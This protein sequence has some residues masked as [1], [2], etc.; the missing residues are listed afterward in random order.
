MVGKGGEG[1]GVVGLAGS[2]GWLA[3]CYNR[4]THVRSSHSR[5]SGWVRLVS[6]NRV[7]IFHNRFSCFFYSRKKYRVRAISRYKNAR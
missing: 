1:E 4:R 3:G 6:Q 5:R 7:R 2:A